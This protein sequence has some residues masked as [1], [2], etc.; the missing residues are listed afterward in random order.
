MKINITKMAMT[1]LVV[2]FAS[3]MS[4][5]NKQF[6]LE[7]LNFG[8]TNYHN[9]I[10]KNMYL[11]WWGDQLME[12]DAEEVLAIDTKSGN[13]TS[14]ATLDDINN[15]LGSKQIHSL[16]SA[17]FPYSDQTVMLVKNSK[18]RMLYNWKSKSIVWKQKCE[19]ETHSD[20]NASSRAVA[21]VKGAQLYITDDANNTKQLTTD[22]SREI[23]Y[24]QSVHRDEFGI[25][26]GTYWSND[27]MKLAFYRMDQSMVTDYP[28]VN[29]FTRIAEYEPDKYPMA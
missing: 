5:Q 19:G 7:D 11:A 4:A 1:M 20:W 29:T 27:G 10:P 28:Q 13:K 12:L 17:K 2:A 15:A 23:V 14:I 3:V 9:M 18:E 8:G 6:T 26:K 25:H 24:G 22:G 16:M 21:F